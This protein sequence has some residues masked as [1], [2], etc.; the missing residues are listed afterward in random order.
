MSAAIANLAELA[1]LN[2]TGAT[3]EQQISEGKA[4]FVL[5]SGSGFSGT[6][7]YR[8]G[9]LPNDLLGINST[10]VPG[11][12]WEAVGYK[13]LVEWVVAQNFS[14]SGHTH[15]AVNIAGL[16]EWLASATI[17]S[18]QI[19]DL[20]FPNSDVS[21]VNSV[22]PDENRN[23]TLAP[24]DIG[25]ADSSD[26]IALQY[27]I[28]SQLDL[29]Q[30]SIDTQIATS[31]NTIID[32]IIATLSANPLTWEEL[33]EKPN[34]ITTFVDL[35]SLMPPSD[36]GFFYKSTTGS[37]TLTQTIDQNLITGLDTTLSA[38][39]LKT[40]SLDSISY[41]GSNPPS[42]GYLVKK[43]TGA[44][45]VESQINWDKINGA[46]E[47][48][49]SLNQL[50]GEGFLYRN[51]SGAWSLIQLSTSQ[52]TTIPGNL[53]RIIS[54]PIGSIALEVLPAIAEDSYVF[55]TVGADSS[56]TEGM[57][58]FSTDGFNPDPLN[59]I[60][61]FQ[62][63]TGYQQYRDIYAAGTSIRAIAPTSS[64]FVIVQTAPIVIK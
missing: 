50:I 30:A 45:E 63:P 11:G 16:S 21:T 64:E 1:I 23:I 17:T 9:T 56:H 26:L 35:V 31:E 43:S 51:S 58:Y 62:L 49:L 38:K 40:D 47:F 12:Y 32:N 2:N 37:L 57:V 10:G 28:D 19:L 60:F 34:S 15:Q 29:F 7:I 55:I 61:S 18:S 39:Q 44:F 54:T 33:Q 20:V 53:S 52:T 46:P 36:K 42:S 3:I 6:F 22:S 13:D 8:Q 5:D 59:N 27:N 41:A 24:A 48:I 4:L 14:M 25:A